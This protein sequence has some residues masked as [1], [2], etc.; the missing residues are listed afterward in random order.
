MNL[1][2]TVEISCQSPSFHCV[3]HHL[4]YKDAT[5]QIVGFGTFDVLNIFQPKRD[6]TLE[7]HQC[8][9]KESVDT[10]FDREFRDAKLFVVARGC[11]KKQLSISHITHG[12]YHQLT[13]DTGFAFLSQCLHVHFIFNISQV[14]DLLGNTTSNGILQFGAFLYDRLDLGLDLT[15]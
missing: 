8:T 15:C 4:L 2:C 11:H 9:L 14:V 7:L 13:V 12:S 10:L 1:Q 5:E 3:F 6:I